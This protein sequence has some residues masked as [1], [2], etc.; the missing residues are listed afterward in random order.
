[1]GPSGSGKSTIWEGLAAA[2]AALGNPLKVYKLNPK[3]LPRQLL[4]GR[5]DLDTRCAAHPSS[6][7]ALARLT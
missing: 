5:L 3:A 7:A 6:R 1:M 4:L 2:Y